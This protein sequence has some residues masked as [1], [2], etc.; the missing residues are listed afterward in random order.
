MATAVEGAQVVIPFLTKQYQLSKNC[1]KELSYTDERK[2]HIVPVMAQKDFQRT[3]W[4][5]IL[6]AGMIWVPFYEGSSEEEFSVSLQSLLIELSRKG[7]L[8][9]VMSEVNKQTTAPP[10][11][12]DQQMVRLV[13]K[14]S[15]NND[16]LKT[17]QSEPSN[18][19]L[20]IACIGQIRVDARGT[21]YEKKSQMGM[22][23]LVAQVV[24][25]WSI[26][27]DATVS[28]V[29]ATALRNLSAVPGREIKQNTS[30]MQTQQPS[31][32]GLILR[33]CR[34]FCADE[35]VVFN[36]LG[37]LI[38]IC[39]TAKFTDTQMF[40]I[41]QIASVHSSHDGIPARMAI[42]IDC[43]SKKQR[44]KVVGSSG[45]SLDDDDWR[46]FLR[47]AQTKA[48]ALLALAGEVVRVARVAK[49]RA[50]GA[51]SA[52]FITK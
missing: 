32:L 41:V 46:D 11:T 40:T 16:L 37:L 24:K 10:T 14:N 29:S 4:L 6:T 42:L 2:R 31:V 30:I 20:Q 27:S 25:A 33:D 7:V 50:S 48:A 35:E 38:N 21:D 26:C 22:C 44:R 34:S 9:T 12:T 15:S 1:K 43:M 39:M 17:M 23:G 19:Q 52:G 28:A 47:V 18:V 45:G 13:R 3:Q 36:C 8:P 5:G 51:S 49:V